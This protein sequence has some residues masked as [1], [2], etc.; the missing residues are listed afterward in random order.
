MCDPP[1]LPETGLRGLAGRLRGRVGWRYTFASLQHP[2][3]RLWFWGQMV[4]LFGTWMQQTA[5]GYFVY[6]LT[7]SPAYLG[8]VG[9]AAGMP[10]WF[11]SLYGGVIADRVNRRKALIATQTAMMFLAFFLAAITFMRVVQG[12]HMVVLAFALGVLNTF[13]APIRLAFVPE[14]IPRQDLTNAVALNGIMFNV[15][16]ALGPAIAGVTYAFFGPGWCF[17]INGIS[18]VAVIVAL[19][20]MRLPPQEHAERRAPAL[21]QV[22]EGLRYTMREPVL[23]TLIGLIAATALFGI[24]FATLIPAWS[25]R[26]LHGAPTL[27]ETQLLTWAGGAF[28][29]V[30]TSSTGAT[31]NGLLLSARG[32]GAL[33]SALFVASIA[34]FRIKGRLLTLGTF[35]GPL[36]L[37]VFAAVRWVPLALLAMFAVGLASI[38]VQNL[39]TALLQNQVDDTMR[40]RVMGL[41]SLTFFGTMP[42]GALWAGA[43]AARI[44][45]PLTV[46]IGASVSL[47]LAA[48]VYLLV[49]RLRALP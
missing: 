18:F 13:E 1:P 26:V 48:L 23:R 15:A 44:G 28:H 16:T 19:L 14:L 27:K 10:A 49:P 38:L 47:A 31:L 32:A 39:I 37:L 6:E 2:N 35:A 22:R 20:L 45:E 36:A 17:T 25:V 3:Y 11:F 33:V 4:S 9:F 40:G 29:W 43:L 41:Y 12:W 24:A 30:D 46:V 34:R 42:L 5:Q 7:R 8:L 21:V